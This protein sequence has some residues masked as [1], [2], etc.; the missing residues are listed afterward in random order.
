M[1][2]FKNVYLTFYFIKWGDLEIVVKKDK[3]ECV[4]I[5]VAHFLLLICYLIPRANHYCVTFPVTVK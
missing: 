2:C 1:E 5:F 3:K 4:R